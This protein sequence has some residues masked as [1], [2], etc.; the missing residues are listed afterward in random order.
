LTTPFLKDLI[1]TY[2]NETM[3]E[4]IFIAYSKPIPIVN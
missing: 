3:M 2:M 1:S 4:T